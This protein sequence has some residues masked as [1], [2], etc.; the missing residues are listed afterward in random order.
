MYPNYLSIQ[1]SGGGAFKASATRFINSLG[2]LFGLDW[3]SN[4]N[5]LL[6]L[7]D[8]SK[9]LDEQIQQISTFLSNANGGSPSSNHLLRRTWWIY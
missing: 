8:S 1:N 2:N 3:I 4:S 5:Q 7:F 9:T 6:N